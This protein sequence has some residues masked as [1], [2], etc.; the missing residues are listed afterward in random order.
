MVPEPGTAM[1]LLAGLLA[2]M[3]AYMRKQKNAPKNAN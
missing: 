3:L 2:V 1:L